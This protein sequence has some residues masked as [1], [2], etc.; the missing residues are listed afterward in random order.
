V[1]MAVVWKKLAEKETRVL[2]CDVVIFDDRKMAEE[3]RILPCDVVIDFDDGQGMVIVKV[4]N[5]LDV[6]EED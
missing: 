4:D 3:G 2:P 5:L 1:R 6:V